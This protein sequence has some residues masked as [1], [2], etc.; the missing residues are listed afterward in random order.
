MLAEILHMVDMFVL[1]SAIYFDIHIYSSAFFC[2]VVTPKQQVL[3][4]AKLSQMPPG[5]L[6]QPQMLHVWSQQQTCLQKC[7]FSCTCR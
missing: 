3:K 1:C 5:V 7:F 6:N 4:M 2:F